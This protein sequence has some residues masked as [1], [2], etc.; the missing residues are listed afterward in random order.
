[1]QATRHS[2]ALFFERAAHRVTVWAGS[3][4]AFCLA[5]AS[6]VVWAC[7]GFLFRFSDTW[8]LVINT[9]TTIVT[10]LMIFLVQRTQN[11]DGLAIHLKLNEIVAAMQGASNRMINVENLSEA[12]VR[13]LQ[14]QYQKLAELE[15][16]E[17][18]RALSIEKS[19]AGPPPHKPGNART[20]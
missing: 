6:I 16:A 17:S 12:E 2:S 14:A 10:F 19:L 15:A 11:K 8:Q 18:T 7:L 3:T 5:V 13:L 9:A 20:R 4:S 1:M